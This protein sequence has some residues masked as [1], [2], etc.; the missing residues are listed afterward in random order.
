MGEGGMKSAQAWWGIPLEAAL[1][2]RPTVVEFAL[3]FAYRTKGFFCAMAQ[4]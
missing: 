4:Q 2:A 1:R 3:H